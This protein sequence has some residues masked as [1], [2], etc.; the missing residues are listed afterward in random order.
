MNKYTLA[1]HN[2]IAEIC[3]K[4]EDRIRELEGVIIE[5]HDYIP[6]NPHVD[7]LVASTLGDE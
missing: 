7:D 6:N 2:T 5:M 3:V 1:K 4:H